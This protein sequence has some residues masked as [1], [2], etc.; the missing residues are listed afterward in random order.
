MPNTRVALKCWSTDDDAKMSTLAVSGGSE[1][2]DFLA[3]HKWISG[4]GAVLAGFG[5]P[6]ADLYHH[7][8]VIP[9]GVPTS[10]S[11][12]PNTT[13][14]ALMAAGKLTFKLEPVAQRF[15]VRSEKLSP[16]V[17]EAQ[18][19]ACTRCGGYRMPIT[20]VVA[21]MHYVAGAAKEITWL[22]PGDQAPSHTVLAR[23]STT[24]V[25]GAFAENPFYFKPNGITDFRII[26]GSAEN[27]RKA[28]KMML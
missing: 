25:R 6:T 14:F 13:Q 7:D 16:A 19:E 9:P 8:L 10:I 27:S 22:V 1:N 23:A 11:F 15:S 3:R 4:A 21:N 5:R 26:A 24:A 2:L 20:M 17:V 28:L 12:I 18:K